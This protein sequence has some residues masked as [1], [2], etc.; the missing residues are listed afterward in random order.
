MVWLGLETSYCKLLHIW[1]CK[2]FTYIHFTYI[3]VKCRHTMA[4]ASVQVGHPAVI[5][6][7]EIQ[8]L[9][10]YTDPVIEAVAF[11][12]HDTWCKNF[13]NSPYHKITHQVQRQM[14]R[15]ITHQCLN[16]SNLLLC[17]KNYTLQPTQPSK[18]V[19]LGK[20]IF[21]RKASTLI[22]SNMT[23]TMHW[24]LI[25]QPWPMSISIIWKLF[26]MSPFSCSL[27]GLHALFNSL[28]RIQK[29]A[30]LAASS[31]SHH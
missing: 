19:S 4:S 23:G 20:K 14:Q 10:C 1:W 27:Q 13:Q 12:H 3:Y 18:F 28:I 16:R 9:L 8:Q 30:V 25:N 2:V 7:M 22:S 11:T 26:R 24:L 31:V 29:R 5:W 21:W 6:T 15:W 17:T